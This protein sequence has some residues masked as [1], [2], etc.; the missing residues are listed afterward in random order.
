M[1]QKY[2]KKHNHIFQN[3]LQQAGEKEHAIWKSQPLKY[4]KHNS[5]QV[6]SLK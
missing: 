3:E 2:K 1:V 6:Y 5:I 4:K